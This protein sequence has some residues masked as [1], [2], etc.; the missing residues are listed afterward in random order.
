MPLFIA[1][2]FLTLSATS[3]AAPPGGGFHGGSFW[4]LR[5][6]APTH[7]AFSP[8]FLSFRRGTASI[9]FVL[10][11]GLRSLSPRP[12]SCLR[13]GPV[14]GD[15]TTTGSGRP[16]RGYARSFAGDRLSP[17]TLRAECTGFACG[18]R[19]YSGLQQA[20]MTRKPHRKPFSC[21]TRFKPITASAGAPCRMN[22]RF[23]VFF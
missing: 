6:G 11:T 14:V 19:C 23:A 15:G 17:F 13:S 22:G 3:H 2:A 12:L 4:I 21:R 5:A 9:T 8:P 16:F 7:W 18:L 10:A 1:S 20:Q